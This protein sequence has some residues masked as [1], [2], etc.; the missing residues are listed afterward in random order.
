MR[1]AWLMVAA[2]LLVVPASARLVHDPAPRP[3]ERPVVTGGVPIHKD[4]PGPRL[5]T[6]PDNTTLALAA[7]FS[8]PSAPLPCVLQADFLQRTFAAIGLAITQAAA[9]WHVFSGLSLVR[10]F[11]VSWLNFL[12]TSHLRR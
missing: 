3:M 11:P 8:A 1:P 9:R 7:W 6:A 2:C 10:N 5:C 12:H 4:A